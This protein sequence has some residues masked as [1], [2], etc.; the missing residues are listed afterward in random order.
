MM[1]GSFS[2]LPCVARR[3][4]FTLIEL[5]VVI[6]IIA[7]LV[8]ILLPTLSSARK[9]ATQLSCMTRVRALTQ[10]LAIYQADNRDYYPYGYDNRGL[11]GAQNKT[12]VHQTLMPYLGL[13]S[14]GN[15]WVDAENKILKCPVIENELVSDGSDYKS[16]FGL[17]A[18]NPLLMGLIWST[19]GY[20]TSTVAG[21]PDKGT[22]SLFISGFR[23]V[24]VVDIESRFAANRGP[25]STVVF[26]DGF[27]PSNYTMITKNPI[28]SANQGSIAAPHFERVSQR[29]Y[30]LTGRQGNIR[31][32]GGRTN[33]SF[34]DGHAR[35]AT[36]DEF[37]D[38]QWMP[39]WQ[40][41]P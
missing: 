25:S 34:M 3:R 35:S 10:A 28:V 12:I 7:L 41:D 18:Y 39:G 2:V 21:Q 1:I 17:F 27:R 40:I 16:E 33:V 6:S 37:L 32:I 22:Y 4:G 5:L 26:L 30:T 20:H 24:N 31:A 19:T 11:A 36:P 14:S 9:S 13:R 8:S 15:L 29:E 38:V 23:N